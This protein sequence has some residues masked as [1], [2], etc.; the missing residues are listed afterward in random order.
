MSTTFIKVTGASNNAPVYIN[1]A[2]IAM[3]MANPQPN[4]EGSIIIFNMPV[5]TMEERAVHPEILQVLDPIDDLV[6]A[7]GVSEA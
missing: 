4:A 3:T 6:T 5:G 2:H 1:P 7:L